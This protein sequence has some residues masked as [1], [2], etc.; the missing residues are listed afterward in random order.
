[1]AKASHFHT[2]EAAVTN[3]LVLAICTAYESGFGRG[4]SK[5]DPKNPY[6]EN[7][8]EADAY[9]YGW[10]QGLS[11]SEEPAPALPEGFTRYVDAAVA[12]DPASYRRAAEPK[13]PLELGRWGVSK[14]DWQWFRNLFGEIATKEMDRAFAQLPDTDETD[15]DVCVRII[16]QLCAALNRPAE[17]TS[18]PVSAEDEAEIDE[19]V[20]A[21]RISFDPGFNH[22]LKQYCTCP[23][24]G[25][26][27][28][29]CPI[30]LPH[31]WMRN[32]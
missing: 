9:A 21:G 4:L 20:R 24:D 3:Q 30:S 14:A 26:V 19:A 25:T 2:G 16:N 6:M 5:R 18:T 13:A 17:P 32:K 28:I 29:L 10:T 31:P 8:Q 22:P 23:G 1:V 12:A 27:N 7:T 15:V 11:R